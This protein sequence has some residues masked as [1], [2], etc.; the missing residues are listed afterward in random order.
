VSGKST[1]LVLL[2]QYALQSVTSNVLQKPGHF[3]PW[4]SNL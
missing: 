1:L 4:L 3:S 2:T